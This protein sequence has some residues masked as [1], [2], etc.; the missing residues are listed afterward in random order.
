MH[1]AVYAN[2]LRQLRYFMAERPRGLK[3]F[4][5]HANTPLLLALKLSRTEMAWLMIRAGSDLDVP[6]D[7]SFH[8]LVS[9]R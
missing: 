7:G 5:H 2:D 8:L 1:R 3:Q 4:D 9:W 6:S